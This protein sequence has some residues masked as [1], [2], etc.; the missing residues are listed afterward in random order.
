MGVIGP[1]RVAVIRVWFVRSGV[2]RVV[3]P[4]PLEQYCQYTLSRRDGCIWLLESLTC[5]SYLIH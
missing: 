4:W 3:V 5:V 2:R 1:A